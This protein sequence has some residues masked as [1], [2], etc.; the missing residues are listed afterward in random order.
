MYS[1][2]ITRCHRTAIVIA[3][4][5]S[6]SMSG[7][8]ELNGE[9]LS[10]ADAVAMVTGR[11]IEELIMRSYSGDTYRYY[12]DVAIIGYS[13]NRVYSLL[14]ENNGFYPITLLATQKRSQISYKLPYNTLNGGVSTFYERVPMWVEPRAEG[15]TPMYMMLN[16]VTDL[17]GAWC[18]KRDN[19]DSFP[20]I[21]INITDGE[22]SDAD[23]DMLRAAASRLKATGTRD[24]ATLLVN[25]HI[26]S[27]NQQIPIIFPTVA[28]MT[29]ELRYANVLME[30]S[31]VVP[32]PF[33]DYVCSCRSEFA[34]A[35]YIAMS[36]NAS[37]S[38]LIAMLN[39]GTRSSRVGI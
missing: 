25:V 24:G 19:R 13:D 22:A 32:E 12:Y 21:V 30:I 29:D 18:A 28:E 2:E 10:K 15:N 11:L 17:V 14:G 20:P 16:S 34:E 39:I 6:S 9:S 8:I 35:P 36:Y 33:N 5:Q 37:I 27:S 7:Q 23:Y 26:S 4:D 1:R 3:I 38:E 31:S